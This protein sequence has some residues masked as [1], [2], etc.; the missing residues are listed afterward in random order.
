MEACLQLDPTDGRCQ[1]VDEHVHG[2]A[3]DKL[4]WC[5]AMI[6]QLQAIH[7]E[8]F[9]LRMHVH[10]VSTVCVEADG[11]I[12]IIMLSVKRCV[13]VWSTPCSTI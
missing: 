2:S 7:K 11:K 6:S 9:Q 5:K 10:M 12:S 4:T 8:V 3:V 13:E 1:M